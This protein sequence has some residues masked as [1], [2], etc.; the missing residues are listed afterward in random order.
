MQAAAAAAAPP[1]P[2]LPL[3][4]IAFLFP[5]SLLALWSISARLG[6]LPPQILP[7]PSEV[8]SALWD[9]AATGELASNTGIS[10]LRVVEG[11]AA[12]SALG[13]LLGIAMG[14]CR[15][16]LEMSPGVQSRDDT[17][18]LRTHL[19]ETACQ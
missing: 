16:K 5:L 13:L 18:W 8:G 4:G 10:L 15:R 7:A 9:L 6:W 19:C 1:W 2:S 17:P 11:F 14:P 12:G 3:G